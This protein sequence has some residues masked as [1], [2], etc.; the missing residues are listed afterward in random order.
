[1]SSVIISFF[2]P[3][4]FLHPFFDDPLTSLVIAPKNPNANNVVQGGKTL[5]GWGIFLK[6]FLFDLF[7]FTVVYVRIAIGLRTKKMR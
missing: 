2:L 7:C 3:L 5:G 4:I 6:E 1:M